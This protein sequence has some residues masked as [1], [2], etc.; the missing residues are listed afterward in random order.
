[1]GFLDRAKEKAEELAKQAR[2]AAEQAKVKAKPMADK[3][4]DRTGKAAKSLKDSAEGFRGGLR[5]DDDPPA[6]LKH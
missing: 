6:P 3:L 2:P 5:G 1:M 4:R